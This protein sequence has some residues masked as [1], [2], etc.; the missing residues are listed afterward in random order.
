VKFL[1]PILA[2]FLFCKLC[3]AEEDF[4][5]WTDSD[6]LQTKAK[7]IKQV[8]NELV[9]IM[10]EDGKDYTLPVSRFSKEDQKY[11]T[12]IP[13]RD[14]FRLPEPFEDRKKG[15]AIIA[16]MEGRVEILDPMLN[17]KTPA[18]L[19]D[20]ITSPKAVITG[21]NGSA[22]IIFS[23]GTTTKLGA[24]TELFLERIWQLD[25]KPPQKKVSEITEETSPC[26]IALDLEFGDLVVDVKK[27]K[28]DSSFIIHS[29][30]AVAGIRGTQFGFSASKRDLNLGVLE[31][32]VIVLDSKK[33]VRR[34]SSKQKFLG[35]KT[36]SVPIAEISADE[37]SKLQESIKE[38]DEVNN[39][40]NVNSLAIFQSIENQVF[41]NSEEEKRWNNAIE[42]K[43]EWLQNS[44]WK[45]IPYF[46]LSDGKGPSSRINNDCNGTIP[47]NDTQIGWESDTK[48]YSIN[49]IDFTPTR[50]L[51]SFAK[52]WPTKV[53]QWEMNTGKLK[54][55]F[56]VNE[57][58]KL[59][60]LCCFTEGDK[61][62]TRVYK[63]EILQ[64]ES[65]CTHK[66]SLDYKVTFYNWS[67]FK[68][69]GGPGQLIRWHW[70][71]P[72][73]RKSGE[74]NYIRGFPNEWITWYPNGQKRIIFKNYVP[75]AGQTN[76][77]FDKRVIN[78]AVI[79]VESWKP[80]GDKCP[81]TNVKDGNGIVVEYNDNGEE[82]NRKI[83][84]D[85]REV[86]D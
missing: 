38:I 44:D 31:G 58:N 68:E 37:A 5:T 7:F 19:G 23:S 8:G 48:F 51:I 25:F 10:T 43:G 54:A 61:K 73:G 66:Q 80:N 57:R 27:L 79:S 32:K 71:Y 28:K 76:D 2:L 15:V 18:K 4:R 41:E 33:N 56:K 42:L 72:N 52:G 60:G 67:F 29:P 53:T 6:G 63:D 46:Y 82:L 11:I 21:G 16:S 75:D 59:D 45:K 24:N 40:Y 64:R 9:K 74:Q 1:F 22:V 34:V 86:K 50:T 65:V 3:I 17:I 70:F 13:I 77:I 55:I 62:Y 69:F 35:D 84:K 26:R 85:G 83:Y 14:S 81:I 49:P 36:G 47:Q 30:L 39:R 12:D 78:P 20:A